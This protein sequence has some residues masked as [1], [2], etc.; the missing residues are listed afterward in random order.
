MS[1]L[2]I[3]HVLDTAALRKIFTAQSI[4]RRSEKICRNKKQ[5]LIILLIIYF[6]QHCGEKTSESQKLD[7]FPPKFHSCLHIM[8]IYFKMTSA[9]FPQQQPLPSNDKSFLISLIYLSAVSA[10]E[11]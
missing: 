8:Y 2:T 1:D 6:Y 11:V 10:K 7:L 5:M 4:N 9:L 3:N